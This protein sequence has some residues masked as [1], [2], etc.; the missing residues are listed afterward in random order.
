MPTLQ[1]LQRP[2]MLIFL[3]GAGLSAESGIPTFRGPE[4]YWTIGSQNYHPQELATRHSF[5]SMPAEVWAWY[6]YRRSVCHQ[7]QPNQAHSIIANLGQQFGGERIL[8][9]TQNVDGLHL[10]AGSPAEA[11]FEIHGNIDYFRCWK[12]CS[13]TL[14]PLDDRFLEFPKSRRLTAQEQEAF[15]CPLC[16]AWTRPHVLWFDECYDEDWFR[17]QSSRDAARK[18][19]ALISIGTSGQTNLPV[20]MGHLAAAAGALLVDINPQRNPFSDL[21]EAHGGV[22]LRG[23]ASKGM[24]RIGEILSWEV[25]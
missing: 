9:V 13:L 22:F 21:A 8:V 11:T 2:G 23:A 3:T 18:A 25:R 19:R 20:Q 1:D 24:K 17:Y 5:S 15:R 14:W 4:G 16:G 10:R 6:L 12:D 7:A